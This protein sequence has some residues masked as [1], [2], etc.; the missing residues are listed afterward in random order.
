MSALLHGD[1]WGG[2]WTADTE[3]LPWISDPAVHFGCREAELAFT[4][5]FG[6]FPPDFYEAYEACSPLLAGFDERVDLW[7]LYPLLT[8]ANMFG[9]GY[10]DRA[11]R[12]LQRYVG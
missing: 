8:H 7:N 9:G 2:N 6:G 3:G 10:A 12:I 1:L 5:L 11:E 4:H